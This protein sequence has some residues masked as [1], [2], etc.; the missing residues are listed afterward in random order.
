M[1]LRGSAFVFLAATSVFVAGSAFP[2][3]AS[4]AELG[5]LPSRRHEGHGEEHNIEV[6]QPKPVDMVG[7][8]DH[9]ESPPAHTGHGPAHSHGPPKDHFDPSSIPP[10]P[11]SYFDR[12]LG[13]DGNGFLMTVHIV[14]MSLSWMGCLPLSSLSF[15]STL[16]SL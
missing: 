11:L 5:Q 14:F 3:L 13:E 2:N 10:D 1:L 4:D 9:D 16:G 6:N 12:D 7:V 15:P 8:V